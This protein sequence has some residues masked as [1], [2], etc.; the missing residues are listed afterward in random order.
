[1]AQTKT[2]RALAMRE[3]LVSGA[4]RSHV[5]REVQ[6]AA[7]EEWRLARVSRTLGVSQHT[8]IAWARLDGGVR[9]LLVAAYDRY[10]SGERSER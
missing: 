10:L 6:R 5:L 9:A 7:G 3:A 1:M 4:G 8:L 2:S